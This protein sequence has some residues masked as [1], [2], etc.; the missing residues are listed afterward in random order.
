MYYPYLRCKQFELLAIRE[1]APKLG[2]SG[3]IS[4][5]LEPIKKTTTSLEK[6]IESLI[7]N[8]I[9]FTLILNPVHGEFTS[10]PSMLITMI[11]SKLEEYENFQFGIII[12]HSFDLEIID[13][14][15]EEIN[16]SRP[17]AFIHFDRINDIESLT[18]WAESK[19]VKLNFY[20]EN[21]P[22]RRYRG[23]VPPESKVILE[24]KFN[25][26]IKNA[27][28]LN[29]PDEFFSDEYLFYK[30]DGYWGFGDYLTIGNDFSETGFLPYAVA[31][32]LTYKKENEEIWVRHFVSDSNSDNTDVAGKFGEA[33]EKLIAFINE[34][35]IRTEAANEFREH[36]DNQHYPGLG[37][38]KKLSI[39]NHIELLTNLLN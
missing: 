12:T 10:D 36:Y 19:E 24:D 4:P 3:K 33:L 37:S 8:N 18:E 11:N 16:F 2:E 27:D 5:I 25:Q 26:Q 20:N 30:D 35:D 13:H 22:I 14:I 32:H 1:L 17:I 34:K 15:L 21:I 38:I 6:A 29:V 7:A 28:Y 39:K 9:N 31:I 23:I